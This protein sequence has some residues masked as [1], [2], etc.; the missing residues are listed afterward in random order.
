MS[1]FM[2]M[3]IHHF[4]TLLL[5][6]FSFYTNLLR[7][8]IVIMFLHDISDPIMELAKIFLYFKN[9]KKADIFFCF[10]A[11]FFITT[12]CFIYPI[13]IVTPAL[14]YG[15]FF[16]LNFLF[17][18]QICA[19]VTLVLLNLIWSFYISKMVINYFKHG[20][21]KGD[22]RIDTKENKKIKKRK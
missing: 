20:K 2:Q 1:D 8:G 21:V 13:L 3:V 12:R 14:Y 18:L 10:F 15:Y 6:T 5:L 9:Q 11:L 17:I 19:L 22:I 4:V 16:G 7:Y